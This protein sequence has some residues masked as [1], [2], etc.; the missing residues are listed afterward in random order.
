MSSVHKAAI[1]LTALPEDEAVSVMGLLDAN[2]VEQVSIEIARLKAISADEQ[3][4]VIQEF[5]DSNPAAGGSN[6]GGVDF[7]K[8]LVQKAL[9]KNADSTLD[10]IR[11]SIE[12]VPF[13]FLR[14][15][16]S[17]NILTY[18]IDEHPQ[19]IALILS[20]LPA[21]VG[22]EIL[23]GLP[24]ERQLSVI[25][26]IASMSQ[27]SPEIIQEVENGLEH[28]MA[29]VMSQSFENAGGV[30]SI[31]EI[32]NVSDRATERTLLENLNQED[33]DLVEEIRRLMFIF[34][35][36]TKFADKDIQ[37][38]LKNVENAQWALALKGAS[39]TL[40]EKIFGNMS[41]RASEMLNEEMEYMG[42][43]KLSAV[44]STQQEIVDIVRGL[45]D[46]GEIEINTSGEVEE[47]IS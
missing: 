25:Q 26:R 16:D 5:A 11:H 34:E 13:S 9:G 30:A 43:V 15:I 22:A 39:E 2:Q 44:E 12:A 8:S 3:E 6:A 24:T 38:V 40:K 32:L 37:T 7:A 41:Q 10:N 35:D 33:P 18:I 20:H 36:I 4:R 14:H 17:Q 23:A 29:S 31:A 46:T 45:E 19:T 28:R 1:L 27:T 21:G 42:S 47:M